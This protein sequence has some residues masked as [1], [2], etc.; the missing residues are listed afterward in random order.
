MINLILGFAKPSR[1]IALFTITLYRT[2]NNCQHFILAVYRLLLPFYPAPCSI[3]AYGFTH[4]LCLTLQYD[5]T[6]TSHFEEQGAGFATI[7][8]INF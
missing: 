4:S 2:N 3:L 1:F 8:Y 6:R 5:I 7:D